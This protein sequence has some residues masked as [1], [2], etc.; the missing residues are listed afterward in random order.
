MFHDALGS[1]SDA[2]GSRDTA[3]ENHDE[4]APDEMA[5]DPAPTAEYVPTDT[6]NVFTNFLENGYERL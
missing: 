5:V 1:G 3:D 6:G 4:T 2:G